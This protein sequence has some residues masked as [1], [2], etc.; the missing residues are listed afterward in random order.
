[1]G[2]VFGLGTLLSA[3]GLIL[4]GTATMRAGL[5]R[6]WRRF[7]PLVTG[8]WTLVLLGLVF[9]EVMAAGIAVYG[10]C[11]LSL[12]VALYTWPSPAATAPASARV[13]A[14]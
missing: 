4:A 7:T 3:I 13:Q 12:G 5:W 9:T 11:F 1:M 14:P 10:L 6:D 8:I 2:A